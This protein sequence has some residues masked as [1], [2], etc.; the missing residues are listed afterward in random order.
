[1]KKELRKS[2]AAWIEGA[3][4]VGFL[5]LLVAGSA[6]LGFLIAWPLWFFATS[7]RPAYTITVLALAFAGIVFL[8][9]R[10]ARNRRRAVRDAGKPPRTFLSTLLGFLTVLVGVAGVY[11]SAA[12]IVR[13]LWII[14]AIV[15]LLSAGFLW[16]LGR[17]RGAAKGRKVSAVP[18]ENGTE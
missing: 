8:I 15:I 4:G 18:A 1:V 11:L 17:A 14:A 7:A 2:I 10:A 9:V 16:L 13:G 6:A 12:L 3:R 5:L